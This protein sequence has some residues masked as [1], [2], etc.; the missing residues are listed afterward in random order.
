M[1][2]MKLSDY[3]GTDLDLEVIWPV[4]F[5]FHILNHVRSPIDH[6]YTHP[7]KIV[8]MKKSNYEETES[9]LLAIW[10]ED[11]KFYILDLVRP[12]TL[13]SDHPRNMVKII[14]LLDYQIWPRVIWPPDFKI[15][16][17]A[18]SDHKLLLNS[19]HPRKIVKMKKSNYGDNNLDLG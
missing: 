19:S 7:R 3:E 5:K 14:E 2:K 10:H 17:L 6:E 18:S 16:N 9:D 13:N 8:K 12:L 11:F 1:V 15:C 4:Q